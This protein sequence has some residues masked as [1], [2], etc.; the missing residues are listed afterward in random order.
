MGFGKILKKYRRWTK[1]AEQ[2]RRFKD[3]VTNS[4]SSFYQLDLGVLLDR[5]IDVLGTLR[6]VFDASG[7]PIP[8]SDAQGSSPASRITQAV[9]D[10]TEVD[11]DLALSLTPLGSRGSKATYWIHPDHI[12]EVEVLLLQ[13]MRLCSGLR[14]PQD[15]RTTTPNRRISSANAELQPDNTVCTGQ[16]VL[17]HPET[18]AIKQ[19][20]STIGS[21]EET[22]GTPQAK[23]AGIVRWTASGDAVVV[24][25]LE[26]TT[27][28]LNSAKLKRKYVTA[29]LDTEIPFSNQ[30]DSES[31]ERD[32]P[33]EDVDANVGI[34]NTRQ[35]LAEHKDVKPI[36]GICSKRTRFDGL[37]NNI[38]GGMWATLD[39]NIFMKD[40]MH[41]VLGGEEW[42]CDAPPDSK[43]FPHAV[44][45]V[46]RE[47]S[48]SS[49]L[50]QTLDRSHLVCACS[51]NFAGCITD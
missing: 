11:F 43:V 13:Q 50:I 47:G 3:E 51:V 19:N 39:S 28:K 40:S 45:E 48:H 2:D 8:P 29:F 24:V 30:P 44:L 5:Y 22:T 32:A 20:A 41:K 9:R 4:P 35:W 25:G 15:S 33:K 18:F 7:T 14:T 23:A 16:L 1:D 6:A 46:R 49:T 12:V 36:A 26:E 37:H 21:S 34:T 31:H 17:D 10:G 42:C 27:R 38:S